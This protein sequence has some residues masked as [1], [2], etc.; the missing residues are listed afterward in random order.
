MENFHGL[1]E[2]LNKLDTN[3]NYIAK[4]KDMQ[5]LGEMAN[6]RGRSCKIDDIDFSFYFSKKNS[7]HGIR[8]KILW[9]REKTLRDDDG[10]IELHGDYKYYSSPKAQHRPK[11]W[12]IKGLQYFCRKYKVLF[13]AVWEMKLAEDDLADYF[14]EIITFKELVALFDN[15]SEMNYFRVNHCNNLRELEQCVRQNKIFNMND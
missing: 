1:W 7:N 10:Y 3:S 11:Q 5:V 14:K 8:L 12:E 6:V 2:E 9:N 4:E 13:A 15:I